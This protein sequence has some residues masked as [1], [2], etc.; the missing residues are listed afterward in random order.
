MSDFCSVEAQQ[1][2]NVLCLLS[3]V[4]SSEQP[5]STPRRACDWLA[6]PLCE[7][8]YDHT[9]FILSEPLTVK[10]FQDDGVWY[11]KDDGEHFLACGKSME[12]S[13]H[14]F[15]EDFSVYWRVIAQAPDSEL[16]EGAQSLKRFMRSIVREIKTE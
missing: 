12:C 3:G 15:A 16:D 4:S 13:V 8:K 9:I 10:L 14:S 6:F 5:Q 2:Q 7:I 11:C 1:E